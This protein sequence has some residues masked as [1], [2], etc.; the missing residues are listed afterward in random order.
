MA[1]EIERRFLVTGDA[2]RGAVRRSRHIRQGYLARE[3]GVA[4]RLRISE[5]GAVL[6]VKGPGGLARA[7]FEYPVP[8]ADAEG[9]FALAAGR[10]LT[11]TRHEV[12][13]DGLVW[14]V[15]EFDGRLAG[16]VI[17]EVELDSPHHPI[18]PP[19]WAGPEIT[20]D[21]RYSNAALASAE[22]PPRG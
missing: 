20:G 8:A 19:G 9:L 15:D 17:A 14:E 18:R 16:L 1:T 4:V 3:D 13:H 7:E 12:L 5:R 22:S 21:P 10:S 6:T 2:W 11:K